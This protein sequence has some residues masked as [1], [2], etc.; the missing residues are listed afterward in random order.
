MTK[1]T[2]GG[3]VYLAFTFTS[4]SITNG[5]QDIN[6]SKSL[7]AGADAEAM[8]V[9]CSLACLLLIPCSACFLIEPRFTSPGMARPTK[10]LALPHHQLRK[11]PTDLFTA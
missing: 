8:E 9:C 11:C 5:S 4:Q 6:S 7:K 10:V 2:W 1:A 3:K